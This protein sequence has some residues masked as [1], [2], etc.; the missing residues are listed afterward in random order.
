[1]SIDQLHPI[2]DD[3]QIIAESLKDANIPSLMCA[4]VHM[5]GDASVIRGDIR[6]D[7]SV[8]SDAQGGIPEDKQEEIREQALKVIAAYRDGD[9]KL[10]EVPD[11][12]VIREM[13]N[14]I[15]GQE[16][17]NEYVEFLESELSLHGEEPYGQPAIDGIPAAA[18][19][20]FKVVI[21]GAGMSGILAGIRLKAVGIPYVILEKNSDVGGTWYENTYPG[22]RVDSANHTY[23]YSFAPNDW[24][25]HF[26]S[27]GVLLD[28]FS[29]VAGE[30]DIS[31]TACS[32][33]RRS[34]RRGS[35]S[36]AEPGGSPFEGE[37]DPARCWRRMP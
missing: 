21:I 20:G 25:Q 18:R 4:I 7:F 26:S 24:P 36:R 28:Y 5:T 1:M 13:L 14:F 15:T 23:S 33:I 8:M 37:T 34:N 35:M 12:R 29:R 11:E 9:G 31:A 16:V 19:E 22:C 3:D 10:P 2:A 32:L 17:P 6:P 30:Y 27:Q